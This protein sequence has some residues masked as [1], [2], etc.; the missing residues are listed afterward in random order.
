MNADDVTGFLSRW[1][2]R[3]LARE[4][5]PETPASPEVPSAS[6]EAT[7]AAGAPSAPEPEPLPPVESLTPDSDFKPF[8]RPEV[9]PG[10]K[11][12]AMK[13][14]FKDPQFN[15]MDGLDT[16]IEDYGV[17]DPIPESM[18]KTLYQARQHVWSDEERAAA[19]KADA[20]AAVVAE[21]KADAE[22]KA[23]IEASLPPADAYPSEP[24]HPYVTDVPD[25]KA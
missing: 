1:S 11:Q 9:D 24:P 14:L 18:M 23:T 13:Q 12:A 7:P 3:K 15:V 5:V 20:E 2:R 16:Y 17:P 6:P 25:Q 8:M 19:D 10:I 22:A 21:A 4:E